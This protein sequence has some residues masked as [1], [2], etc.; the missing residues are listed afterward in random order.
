VVAEPVTALPSSPL[1]RLFGALADNPH[2]RT[3]WYGFQVTALVML[4]Q[5]VANGYLAFV[6]THSATALGVMAL[7]SSVP[8]LVFSPAG[9]VLADRMEKRQLL[10]ITQVVQCVVSLIMGILVATDHVEYWHLLVSSVITGMGYAVITPTRQAWMP[11]LVGGDTVASAVALNNA[12]LN[13]S[14]ITGPA[15]AG[16]LIAIP[17]F[18]VGGVFF[19]RVVG[20]TW[21]LYSLFQIPIRG[22]PEPLEPGAQPRTEISDVVN[23]LTIGLRYILA[24]AALV[25]LFVFAMV[26]MLLGQSYQQLLPAYALEVFGVGPQG[27]GVM[28]A[29]VGAG[30]LF[31]S[32]TVAYFSRTP[33]KARMQTYSGIVLGL[34]LLLFGVAAATRLFLLALV[35]LF[36]VGLVLDFNTTLNQTLIML[37]SERRLY[38]RVT[39][40]YAMTFSLSGFS[41]SLAGYLMDTLGGA[42]TMLIQGSVLIV[43]VVVLRTFYGGYRR[44]RDSIE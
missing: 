20:F 18:G 19:L 34:A 12:G 8:I 1:R 10:V 42:L 23:Q 9:G 39:S 17:W 26:N 22:E 11:H 7:A 30:A 6:L 4:M 21:V 32:L 15:L 3:Y 38:G 5:S 41:A 43:F 37:N 16:L 14:R 24:D 25:A 27:Q 36:L 40:V 35:A 29:L 13:A 28:Q 33:N 2:Y 44:I 31:G